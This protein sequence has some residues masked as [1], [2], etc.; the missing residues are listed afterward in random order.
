VNSAF[1]DE[2]MND[3]T[4]LEGLEFLSDHE[5]DL[6]EPV[7]PAKDSARKARKRT[8]HVS[9]EIP[10]LPLENGILFLLSRK[11]IMIIQIILIISIKICQKSLTQ[12]MVWT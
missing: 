10:D 5:G 11:I 2:I 12:W 6:N 7:E 9:E 1:F 8:I 3:R 4:S